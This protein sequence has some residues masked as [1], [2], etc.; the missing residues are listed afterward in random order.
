MRVRVRPP[1]PGDVAALEDAERVCFADPWPGHFFATE[2]F[3]P[4]RFNRLL[5]DASGRMV[6]YLFSVWQYLDLHVLKV[7]TLP[8]HRRAGLARRL[9][10][11][12][13]DH[14]AETG[15]ESV[16]LEV[17]TA[18][19]S[20]ITLYRSLGYERVGLRPRYY[21]DGEDAVIM[22]RRILLWGEREEDGAG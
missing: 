3:A 7:A 10:L 19:S 13:E 2:M 9:M 14:A 4:G 15:G 6:A 11:L 16:T 20:A 17:R 18:N 12:A 21:A 22:T 1:A 8:A 5:V